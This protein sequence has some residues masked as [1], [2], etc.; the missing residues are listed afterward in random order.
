M[1]IFMSYSWIAGSICEYCSLDCFGCTEFLRSVLGAEGFIFHGWKICINLQLK[2]QSIDLFQFRCTW[3]RSC[4]RHAEIPFLS[5]PLLYLLLHDVWFCFISV[6]TEIL[7]VWV[8]DGP[9]PVL[10][11]LSRLLMGPK[12]QSQ[13]LIPNYWPIGQTC[14]PSTCKLFS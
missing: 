10:A 1:S 11:K 6:V 2:N 3:K 4:F 12:I 8:A 13:I 14:A 5:F 7:L 9:G